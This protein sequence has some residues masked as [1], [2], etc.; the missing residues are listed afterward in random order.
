M[1]D[2]QAGKWVFM[3]SFKFIGR[4]CEIDRFNSI[5]AAQEASVITVYGR[6]RI[7]KTTLI[8]KALSRYALI[9]CEGIEGQNQDFQRRSMLEQFAQQ[10]GIPALKHATHD[11]WRTVLRII[12]EHLLQGRKTLYL[13]E[14]QWLSSYKGELISEI[15]YF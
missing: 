5:M 8:E 2:W 14:F 6:R 15:K 4:G 10:I 11:S 13:E 3:K 9:K 1:Y 12:T 7:G